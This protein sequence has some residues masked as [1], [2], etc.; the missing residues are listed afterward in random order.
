MNP[1]ILIEPANPED[2]AGKTKEEALANIQKAIAGYIAAL[3]A[4]I[5]PFSFAFTTPQTLHPTPILTR[6][7]LTR[8]RTAVSVDEFIALL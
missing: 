3:E 5:Q 1:P 4:D 8:L 6:L 7:W 2:A